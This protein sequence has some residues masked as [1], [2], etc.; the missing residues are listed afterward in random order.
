[1]IKY[2]LMYVAALLCVALG[3]VIGHAEIWPYKL[4]MSIRSEIAYLK[5]DLTDG[6]DRFLVDYEAEDDSRFQTLD[7]PYFPPEH[8]PALTADGA[9][10]GYRLLFGAF[11]FDPPAHAALLLDENN[12]VVHVWRLNED[13][14][15]QGQPRKDANKFPHGM[16]VLPDGSL[17]FAYDGGVSLQ[18][19]DVCSQPQWGTPGHFHHSMSLDADGEHIWAL[20]DGIPDAPDDEKTDQK[21]KHRFL[22]RL[23]LATGEIVKKISLRDI[24]DANPGIDILGLHQTDYDTHFEWQQ[25]SFHENDIEPLSEEMAA[26]FPDFEAGDL[27]LSMRALDLVFV[28]DPDSLEVKWWRMAHTRRQHDADWQPDGR[29]TVFDNDMHRGPLR[30]VSFRPE[31]Q[32][33]EVL[34]EGKTHGAKTWFRGR[35]QLLPGGNLLITVPQQGRI[36]EVTPDNEVVFEF[37][38]K[39]RAEA[40]RNLVLS[41]ARWLPA[42][43]F[44]FKEFPSCKN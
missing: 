13:A 25:D 17:L 32:S 7:S 16:E 10:P 34:Y 41:E 39:Y 12:E 36:L 44:D 24:M 22:A 21:A 3:F 31:A 38:N 9:E 20:L 14:I 42:D 15:R 43:Y 5:S 33:L 40:G 29:I 8:A 35:H 37:L 18:R 30:I 11:D 6:V 26:A 28:L 23:D 27:L 19:F 4:V 1:M 2:A